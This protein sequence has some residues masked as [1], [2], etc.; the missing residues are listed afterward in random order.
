MKVKFVRHLT[1]SASNP[2]FDKAQYAIGE[3]LDTQAAIGNSLIESG[4][5]IEV[6][7]AK[8]KK[9]VAKKKRT[10]KKK[11]VEDIETK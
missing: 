8:P 2:N 7:K 4:F 5:V 6:E 1:V 9:K 3:T 11:V 10:Y